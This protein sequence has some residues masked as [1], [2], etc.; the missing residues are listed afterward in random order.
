MKQN[1]ENYKEADRQARGAVAKITVLKKI[2]AKAAEW[3]RWIGLINKQEFLK[4]KIELENEKQKKN[5]TSHQLVETQNKLDFI[6]REISILD[7]KRLD[8]EQERRALDLSLA[9]NDAHRLYKEIQVRIERLEHDLAKEAESA[10]KY[11]T[12]KS[13]CEVLLNRPL[14]ESF[15]DES[16]VLDDEAKKY[17]DQKYEA[18]RKRIETAELLRYICSEL[19]DLERGI[20]RYPD[21]PRELRAALEIAGIAVII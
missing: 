11:R 9:L 8:A 15:D 19:A 12:L 5:H 6:N 10:E 16:A 13:Q 21:A 20:L 14:S 3:R 7:R 2:C 17:H 18:G 4:L 1:L